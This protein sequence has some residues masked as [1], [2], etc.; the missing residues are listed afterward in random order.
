MNTTEIPLSTV[1]LSAAAE[2]GDVGRSI[3]FFSDRVHRLPSRRRVGPRHV[4]FAWPSPSTHHPLP[5]RSGSA[6]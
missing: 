2:S 4:L 3:G 5:P 1:R 6:A